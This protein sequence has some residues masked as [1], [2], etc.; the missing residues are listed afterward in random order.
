MLHSMEWDDARIF[1]ALQRSKS[2]SGAG[3]TLG[4]NQSTIGRRITAAEESLGAK[5]FF[6]TPDGYVLTPAG[7]R[8]LAHAE[9]ME[10]EAIAIAREL[11]GQEERLTGVVRITAPDAMSVRLVAPILLAAHETYPEIDLE[12]VADNRALSL[13]KREADMA[14]RIGRPAEP[15]LIARKICDFGN[16]LYASKSYIA[17]RGKPDGDYAN[18][19]FVSFEHSVGVELEWRRRFA[20]HARISFRCN[21][22]LATVSACVS[23]IGL[24]ILPCYLGDAEPELV[25]LVGP[26][27]SMTNALWLVMHGDL[28]HSARVRAYADILVAGLEKHAALLSGVPA[29]KK[30]ARAKS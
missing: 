3:R 6:Q 10:D 11:S 27:A 26:D 1:L 28:Q 9:R 16:A 14:V 17:A 22:S 19:A 30:P 4:V 21:A 20:R 7:E 23:G 24:A 15:S 12:L 5:L 8:M 2:L 29:K 25:R 18:H 13:T